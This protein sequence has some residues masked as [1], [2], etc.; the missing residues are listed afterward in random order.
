MLRSIPYQN[1]VL[2][3]NDGIKESSL[4]VET[5]LANGDNRIG[6]AAFGCRDRSCII[7]FFTKN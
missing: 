3:N 4:P 5:S 1:T 2:T 6:D 7:D